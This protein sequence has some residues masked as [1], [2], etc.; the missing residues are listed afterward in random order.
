MEYDP[1]FEVLVEKAVFL[2]YQSM[3]ATFLSWCW[4]SEAGIYRK[5]VI[6]SNILL[7]LWKERAKPKCFFQE[8]K[9]N[10]T[11]N[12]QTSNVW[13]YAKIFL[14]S[15]VPPGDRKIIVAHQLSSDAQKQISL[16]HATVQ[17]ILQIFDVF[18]TIK[19][20]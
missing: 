3:W 7:L 5:R 10:Y 19:K 6:H 1:N 12:K 11:H 16:Q 15:S 14:P 9:E 2:N 18:L 17:M 4:I 13:L 8:H 20:S